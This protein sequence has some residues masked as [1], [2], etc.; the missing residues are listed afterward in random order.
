MDPY[1][2]SITSHDCSNFDEFDLKGR[3]LLFDPVSAFEGLGSKSVHQDVSKGAHE[4]AELV[5]PPLTR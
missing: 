2:S 4:Q 5:T 3:A 1:S